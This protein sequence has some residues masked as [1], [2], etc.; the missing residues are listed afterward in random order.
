MTYQLVRIR[1]VMV[2]CLEKFVGVSEDCGFEYVL[3]LML[4]CWLNEMLLFCCR[5]T[6]LWAHWRCTSGLTRCPASANSAVRRSP[7][8]GCSRA[9]SARTLERSPSRVRT[10]PEPSQTGPTSGP[11][12]RLIPTSKSTRAAPAGRPS[13]GCRSCR[14]TQRAGVRRRRRRRRRRRSQASWPPPCPTTGLS[15]INRRS[16]GGSSTSHHHS[17]QTTHETTIYHHSY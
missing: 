10:A 11:I 7:G 2:E 8:R 16:T 1:F 9:T 14:S 13:P 15:S 6:F 4:I 5:C 17:K 3:L 12:C